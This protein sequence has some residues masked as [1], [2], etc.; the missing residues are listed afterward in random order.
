M[1][2]DLSFIN[3]AQKTL[4]PS[5]QNV[6]VPKVDEKKLHILEFWVAAET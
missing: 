1:Y 2:N 6:S 4:K 5:K 3:T